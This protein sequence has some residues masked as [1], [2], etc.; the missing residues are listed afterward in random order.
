M[1]WFWGRP[2]MDP[3]ES[4]FAVRC[5]YPGLGSHEFVGFRRRFGRALRLAARDAA[6]YR[7]GPLRTVH[8]VVWMSLR[9]FDLHASRPECR[10]PDCPAAVGTPEQVATQRGVVAG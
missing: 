8:T 10:A 2:R 6:F 4:G 1:R 9:D 3:A 5:D 7:R